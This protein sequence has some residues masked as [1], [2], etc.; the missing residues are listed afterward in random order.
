MN[1][2]MNAFYKP[3]GLENI[4]YKPRL[5]WDLNRIPPTEDDKAFRG[6]LIQGDVHDQGAA[7]LGGVCGHA[8]LFAN[9]NDL[10][11]MM[12]MFMQYGEYGGERYMKEEVVKYFTS[13]PYFDSN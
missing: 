6:Q 11:V 13:A 3:L 1:Y 8:G 10:G 7:M 12:Q 4:G 9:A 2:V 5:K